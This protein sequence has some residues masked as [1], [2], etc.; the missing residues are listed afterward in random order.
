MNR[1][2]TLTELEGQDWGPPN[3][4][5]HVVTECHRLR[6]VPLRDLTVE[7]LRLLIGQH[8][9]LVYTVPLALEYLAADRMV[10]GDLYPGDLLQAVKKVP[11]EFWAQ[12]PSLVAAWEKIV[13]GP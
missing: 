13:H 7:H 6:H 1:A 11:R 8:I 4:D 10:S 3:Y 9:S 12:H 5:S 2:R